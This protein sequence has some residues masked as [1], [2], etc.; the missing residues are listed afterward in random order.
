M[1]DLPDHLDVLV[2][3][4]GAPLEGA[5]VELRLPMDR[6]Q[7][8]V[9]LFGPT[10]HVGSLAI[11]HADLETQIEY[12]QLSGFM[13]YASLG[14][15]R[16]NLVLRAFDADAVRRGEDRYRRWDGELR[17]AYPADFLAQMESL[18][19]GLADQPGLA[20]EVSATVGGGAAHVSC[21]PA[22]T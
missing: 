19:R 2:T 10:D 15:W 17:R 9:L 11:S 5:W 20:L 4:G 7:D 6:K 18:A 16:G 8:Y 3:L 14:V 1:P 12:V 21:L 22:S 13:D